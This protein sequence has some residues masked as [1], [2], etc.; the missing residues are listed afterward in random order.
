MSTNGSSPISANVF[1]DILKNRR[2]YYPLSK[3]LTISTDR[4]QEIVK[5]SL[6]HVPSSFNSQTNRVIV[7]FGEEHQKLWDI[8]TEVLKAV[9]PPEKWEPTG[10]KMEMFHGAA[11]TVS[12]SAKALRPG[13]GTLLGTLKLIADRQDYVL[14][15]QACHRRHVS[16]VPALLG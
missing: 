4:I 1:I 8:V 9:V 10:K 11:G 13:L 12:Y 7:L 6:L 5:E 14:R 3:D 16:Q 15:G 2:S